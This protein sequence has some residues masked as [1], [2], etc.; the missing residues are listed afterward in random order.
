MLVTFYQEH[1]DDDEILEE[2]LSS[3]VLE[4]CLISVFC[5]Q[6]MATV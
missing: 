6:T 4:E 2:E 5:L 3:E 1:L